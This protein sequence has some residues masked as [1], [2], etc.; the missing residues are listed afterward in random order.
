MRLVWSPANASWIV[1]FGTAICG[2]GPDN[3]AFFPTK[4]D[5]EDYLR[6]CGLRLA[7]KRVCGRPS[8]GRQIVVDDTRP[9]KKPQAP[10]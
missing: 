2:V 5:A 8:V 6:E 4:R 9:R 1:M 3:R 10:A 7:G